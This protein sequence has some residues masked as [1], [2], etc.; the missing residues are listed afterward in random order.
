METKLVGAYIELTSFCNLKCKHC[1]NESGENKK[2]HLDYSVL[3]SLFN[4]LNELGVNNISFSGGEPLLYQPFFEM[5]D[6]VMRETDFFVTIISN[7]TLLVQNGEKIVSLFKKYPNRIIFQ[8]SIDGMNAEQHD[9][10]RGSGNF[11]KTL[12]GIQFLK[13]EEIPFYFHSVIS[14]YNVNS[15]EEFINFAEKLGATKIDFSHIKNKGRAG[16]TDVFDDLSDEKLLNALFLLQKIKHLGQMTNTIKVNAP[17]VFFGRCPL[18]EKNADEIELSI[19]IDA[20]GNVFPCQNFTS[21]KTIMGNINDESIKDIIH[22]DFLKKLAAKGYRSQSRKCSKCF[23]KKHCQKGCSGIE[24]YYGCDY[25]N[26][27]RLRRLL[28]LQGIKLNLKNLAED[29]DNYVDLE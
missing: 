17:T 27:C 22:T 8:I 26:E 19:R 20:S 4:D 21:E 29:G 5:I 16:E 11:E 6:F 23:V 25:S 24:F 9:A 28:V 3:K 15:L 18:F 12:Q 7:G 10:I 13:N 2:F 1:Y 14:A